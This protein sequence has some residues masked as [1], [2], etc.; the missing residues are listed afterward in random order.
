MAKC[1][2]QIINRDVKVR[3]PVPL[4][5]KVA[6]SSKVDDENFFISFK[7]SIAR[8]AKRL[9]NVDC[10]EVVLDFFS[11]G[12][13]ESVKTGYDWVSDNVNLQ[14]AMEQFGGLADK[15]S[16]SVGF[17]ANKLTTI[18]CVTITNIFR[19]LTFFIENA[20]KVALGLFK[21]IDKYLNQL[22]NAI[23][24]FIDVV[25]DCIVS[26]MVDAKLALNKLVN[27]ILDFDIVSDLMTACPCVAEIFAS[28]FSCTDDNG[29]ALTDPD[30]ILECMVDK[31]A[32]DPSE[33]LGPVNEFIDDTLIANIQRGYNILQESVS[34]MMEL[35]ITPLRELMK[36][37]CFLLTE[38]INVTYII[39]TLGPSK[40]LLVYTTEVDESGRTYEGMSILDMIETLKLWTGCFEFI[41]APFIDDTKLTIKKLREDFRLDAKYWNNV[42]ALD[43]YTSCVMINI[44]GQ[45]TR[46]TAVREVY[47]A[48]NGKGKE[49]F[50][51]ITDTFK[52]LGKIDIESN[53]NNNPIGEVYSSIKFKGGPENEETPIIQGTVDFKSGVEDKILAVTRTIGATI[54]EEPYYERFMNLLTWDAKYRKSQVHID[55]ITSTVDNFRASTTPV[56]DTRQVTNAIDDSNESQ[57]ISGPPTVVTALHLP[58]YSI[59]DDFNEESQ[60]NILT[61]TAP[62][63]MDTE[64][65]VEYYNRWFGDIVE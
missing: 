52:D 31:Y 46:P 51:G 54:G 11:G 6:G 59:P 60:V 61:S 7:D 47:A 25:R 22:E 18:F 32:L 14:T 24:D 41:C 13:S 4:S 12:N 28:I 2:N 5:S 21:I 33:L 53:A 8:S 56:N 49:V 27:N 39:K 17:D 45:T 19:S 58:S 30:E 50:T 35:L 26:V 42:F 36:A 63:R 57:V 3:G 64:N 20:L 65:L 62:N 9:R 38:K 34:F 1:I 48:G 23:Q 40:C 10:S 16:P 29:T 43:I 55:L 15:L 44:T 37:Y